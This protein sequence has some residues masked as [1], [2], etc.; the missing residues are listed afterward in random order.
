MRPMRSRADKASSPDES[1]ASQSGRVPR[2]AFPEGRWSSPRPVRTTYLRVDVDDLAEN[3]GGGYVNAYTMIFDLKAMDADWL[4]I[5]NTGYNNYNEADFWAAADGSVGSGSYSDPGVLPLATWVRLA[6]VRQAGGRQSGSGTSTSTEP[7]CSTTS[8]PKPWTTT[9]ACT[10][11]PNKARDSSR[12][13]R[14]RTPPPTPGAS[15]TISPLWPPPSRMRRLR[16]SG[17]TGPRASSASRAWRPSP[18]PPME[19]RMCR[20]TAGLSLGRRRRSAA[21]ARRVFR[22]DASR[23][24]TTPSRDD[25]KGVLVSQDQTTPRIRSRPAIEYRPD[26]LLANRRSQRGPRQHH[27]QGR[28]LELHGRAVRL[29]DH[30]RHGHG[31]QLRRRAWG[32]RTR[33]TAPGSTPRIEHST[34]ATHM[35][36]PAAGKPHWIQYEFDKVYKLDEL[37]GLELQPVDRGVRGLRRQERHDRVLHRR[38]RPGP[39]WKACRNSPRRPARAT[40]T[41][42]TTVDF[43]GVMAKFVKLTIETNWGGIAPQTGLSEVRFFYVPVQAFEPQPADGAAGVDIERRADLAARPRSHL[44]HGV[45]RHRQPGAVAG[46]T[47]R[48][49]RP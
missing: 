15:S 30:G 39:S 42:N 3:G 44:A 23:T 11:T 6:V 2:S 20:A 45:H 1:D 48:G 19:R 36:M 33:S 37:L 9:A 40:Y 18:L 27:L 34:E 16:T 13:S 25:P 47:A 7:R 8:A 26:L 32:R 41:A 12:S 49:P 4:P 10:R 28:S 35:W 38:R 17:R 46:G 31:L 5:Y 22:D 21:D 43:G 29:S 14:T 24:S